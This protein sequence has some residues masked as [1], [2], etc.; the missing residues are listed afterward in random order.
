M[1]HSQERLEDR[2]KSPASSVPAPSEAGSAGPRRSAIEQPNSSNASG[3]ANRR[4]RGRNSVTQGHTRVTKGR[5]KPARGRKKGSCSS[6][7][8]IVFEDD[9]PLR[10]CKGW[11]AA[12]RASIGWSGRWTQRFETKEEAEDYMEENSTMDDQEEEED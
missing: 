2:G 5:G 6:A 12:R 10:I 7:Y 4:I 1:D 3:L 11:L 9:I 8:Y